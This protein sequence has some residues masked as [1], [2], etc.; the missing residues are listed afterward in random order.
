MLLHIVVPPLFLLSGHT[1]LPSLEWF[2]HRDQELHVRIVPARA[3]RAANAGAVAAP[4]L[5]VRN[6]LTCRA[7]CLCL[8]EAERARPMRTQHPNEAV[9]LKIVN[10]VI[11]PGRRQPCE[12]CD[13]RAIGNALIHDG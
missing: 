5:I 9:V 3:C 10:C 12:G 8:P 7:R 4:S 6:E 13:P 2:E 11:D 1:L